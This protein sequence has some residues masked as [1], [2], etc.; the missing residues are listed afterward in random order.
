MR[1]KNVLVILC[2]CFSFVFSGC[3]LLMDILGGG[4]QEEAFTEKVIDSSMIKPNTDVYLVKLNTSYELIKGKKTGYATRTV[5]DFIQTNEKDTDSFIR[6]LNN[7]I[8][9]GMQNATNDASRAAIDGSEISYGYNQLSY[10]IGKTRKIYTYTRTEKT[11][12]GQ[13]NISEQITGICKYAGK[14]CYVFADENNS[15]LKNKGINLSDD[16]YYNLGVKFDSCYELETKINGDP[17]YTKYNRKWFV[18][19]NDKIIIL[20]SDLFGDAV[21]NQQSGTLGYFYQGDMYN[22]EYLDQ[23]KGQFGGTINSNECE[24][25]YI[26][27]AFLSNSPDMVYST[28]VHEFNHMINYI[29][30][31]VNYMTDNPKN[32]WQ[33]PSVWYTEMLSMTTE[34]MF[35]SYLKTK[36]EDSPKGRLPYFNLYYNYGFNCWDNSSIPDY[37][38]YANT[39]AFG[40]FLVRNF[41]GI[42]LLKEIAQNSYIDKDSITEALK[43]YNPDYT[44]TDKNGNKITI[45]YDFDFAMR[46]FAFCLFNTDKPTSEQLAKTNLEKYYSFYRGTDE[47]RGD[48]L[49]FTPIDINSIQCEYE[50]N[51]VNKTTT[52]KPKIYQKTEG[53]DLGSFGF[54]VHYIGYNVDEFTL[55]ASKNTELEYYLVQLEKE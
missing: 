14:H 52:I 34:D 42:N 8:N 20:V 9:E 53:V 31:T 36:D 51:G 2:I 28:L 24:M 44:Y 25:F 48:G 4:S 16:A 43:K 7:A 33:S 32:K 3:E 11:I 47:N 39:Y 26:D 49:K 21:E 18:P 46:Q 29:I 35:Q 13:S 40:A 22:Q 37:I 12:L 41:G 5:D 55:Y 38:A 15:K 30:K 6:D 10:S 27:A 45:T 54:S 50:E 1:I 23:N 17:F 19:C